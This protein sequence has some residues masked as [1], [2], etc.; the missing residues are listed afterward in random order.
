MN[1]YELKYA[2]INF[3]PK[4]AYVNLVHAN[5]EFQKF[6]IFYYFCFNW[7]NIFYVDD[8]NQKKLN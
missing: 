3:F 2:N 5:I 8:I 4:Y 6:R 1:D 7:Q